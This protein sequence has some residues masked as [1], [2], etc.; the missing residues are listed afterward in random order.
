MKKIFLSLFL[1]FAVSSVYGPCFSFRLNAETT[2]T[3][4]G[5]AALKGADMTLYSLYNDNLAHDRDK[6]MEYAELFLSRVDSSSLS[7]LLAPL[8]EELAS[9]YE[10]SRYKFSKAIQFR[11][12]LLEI[13]RGQSDG[14]KE[15]VTEYNLA[16]LYLKLGRYD[17]TLA[18]ASK[19]SR[20]FEE[21]SDYMVQMMECYKLL[22]VVYATCRDYGKS[23][24]YFQEYAKAARIIGDSVRLFIG[25]NNTAAFASSVGD[26]T[27]TIRL[28]EESI[29]LSKRVR[30]TSWLVKLY[31]NAAAAYTDSH[32]Y[33]TAEEYL[34]K[35]S[36]LVNTDELWGHWWLN[37]GSLYIAKEDYQSAVKAFEKAASYYSKGE[38]YT[39]LP[40]IYATLN[41]LYAGMGDTVMAY[42]N[43][44]SMYDVESNV[45]KDV[46]LLELFREKN[47]IELSKERESLEFD[48]EKSR[49][50]GTIA[51]FAIIVA[52]LAVS[53]I[54]GKR[55]S[56]IKKEEIEVAKSREISEIK[57]NQQFRTDMILRGAID[58][59][60]G[61]ALEAKTSSERNRI[62]TI[63]GE[64][65][66]SKDE[67]S[68]K[69]VEQ[70]VPEFNSTF[71]KNL[72]KDFPDLSIN[73]SRLCV[74]LNRNL[75]TKQ[76]SEITRQSPESI[77]VARTRLRKKL[78][79]TGNDMSIQ[80]FLRK[81]NQ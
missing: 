2:D 10:L 39:I 52:V 56:A 44:S 40:G 8:Y 24:E 33:D 80:E 53:L 34:R 7:P 36:P 49:L 60:Q 5:L 20:F 81:Y 3:L 59:L 15:A 74:F 18:L 26:T 1:V 46:M 19:A 32:R 55:A 57:K 72:I 64:L 6:A 73:E 13:Y 50:F 17:K 21:K 27:K 79:L 48:R 68:W 78:G 43:L 42:R 67:D 61:L 77:N 38:F 12:K 23:D 11:E 22:G 63:I 76:I 70:Y 28:L 47:E 62:N 14:Y 4:A 41:E 35:A 29:E 54:L 71:F 30:D 37:Y 75:S 16:K 9:W 65:R 66:N 45:D 69:E 25:M 58:K 51:L 31:I